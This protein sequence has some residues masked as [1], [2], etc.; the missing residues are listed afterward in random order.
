MPR[1]LELEALE[2][3]LWG[4]LSLLEEAKEINDPV[5]IIQ[6]EQRKHELEH[7]IEALRDKEIHQA[8][9]V[10]YFGGN[11]VFGS[12]GIAADFAGKSLEHFQQI[13]STQFAKA[14]QGAL[15]ERGRVPHKEISKLMLTGVT[16]GSFGFLL[17]ELSDQ[18]QMFDTSMKE[19][20]S[21]VMR[22]IVS[23]GSVDEVLFEETAETLDPRT[24]MALKDFFVDL[25]S[26]A[27]TVRIVDDALDFSLDEAAVHRARVRTEAT[28][29]DENE[30]EI[31]GKLLGF[32][33][34]H[35]TFELRTKLG[36]TIY[37]SATKEA[38]EQYSLSLHSDNPAIG[39][40]C[41][42]K[43]IVKTVRPL[44][45]LQRIV[46]RLLEFTLLGQENP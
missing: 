27:A 10:L 44:N 36:E 39:K 37:G 26:S 13:I 40:M 1:K 16:Q 41:T 15:G 32:L 7:E 38:T 2:V 5:G 22:V 43:L 24:L 8:S 6:Y 23:A 45:R 17:D 20:V 11:P 42:A 29:I 18:T 46:Y 9:L 33:P 31:T 30:T 28:Q 4:I 14:E 12:R 19:M 34:E 25:D 35:R 21:E 3:E